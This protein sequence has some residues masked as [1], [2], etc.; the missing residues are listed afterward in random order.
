MSAAAPLTRATPNHGER[1]PATSQISRHNWYMV[2]RMCR[3]VHMPA[4]ERNRRAGG[5]QGH[6]AEAVMSDREK[7][8]SCQLPTVSATYR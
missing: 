6:A 2:A 1:Q 8:R 3:A 5:A 7:S 4:I